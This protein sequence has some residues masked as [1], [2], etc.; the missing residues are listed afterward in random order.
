MIEC[1]N[2]HT[3]YDEPVAFC[4]ACGTRLAT[5]GA[6][7]RAADPLI[8]VVIDD[9]YRL[10]DL[11]GRGGMGAVYRVEHVKMGKVMAMKLLHG[12]LG[13]DQEVARRFR[14]EAEA[15]SRLTHL[16]T[17]SVFDFGSHQGMMYLVM[18]Y[19]EGRDLAEVLRIEGPMPA[20]RV[21]HVLVQVCSALIEA[22]DKGIVHRDIKPENILVS[23]QYDYPDFV[24]V[25]D[26]GLAKLRDVRDATKITKEGNLVGTPY[27]M[28]PEHIRGEG[29]DARSDV[30]SLGAVMYKLLTGETPFS[31]DTPM[32]VLTKHLTEKIDPPSR[33]FPQR[34]IPPEA[35]RIV[36]RAMAKTP[37]DRY[38][39]AEEM[40]QELAELAVRLDP[41]SQHR[42]L[43]GG[44]GIP[45]TSGAAEKGETADDAT[46]ATQ[47]PAPSV[48]TEAEAPQRST[49]PSTVTVGAREVTLGTREDVIHFEKRL[50]RKRVVTTVSLSLLAAAAI[51]AC[52]YWAL[53]VHGADDSLANAETEPND[54]PATA[55]PLAAGVRLAGT[56]SKSAGQQDVDWY[57]L[58]SPD[59]AGGAWGLQ[60]DV[61]GVPGLDIGL[62][63]V[64]PSQEDPLARVDRN[65]QGGGESI[66]PLRIEIPEV[67]L[68]LQEMRRPGVP[69]SSFAQA[70]YTVSYQAY[71]PEFF[72]I[73]PNDT[74]SQASP[75]RVGEI[76]NGV[77][78][79][80]DDIDWYCLPASARASS[81][82]VTPIPEMQI[83]LGFLLGPWNEERVVEEQGTGRG[84][85]AAIPEGPGPVCFVLRAIR[86]VQ[87]MDRPAE[88]TLMA[89]YQITVK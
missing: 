59:P 41:E 43:S 18:E 8:G 47:F 21:A 27:Y 53:F 13:Q 17:V 83:Q 68:M 25:L 54:S 2:C 66:P 72:E 74:R 30:Y 78:E 33:R 45:N 12:E 77:I 1:P 39:S 46:P 81:V 44:D 58:N 50:R 49:R 23:Q 26:F 28:A 82:T 5:D 64:D 14:L 31:A 76:K 6:P 73:E 16:N 85:T 22:H 71:A 69:P 62:Q 51:A 20:A 52:V 34:A 24:K 38:A 55:D 7:A 3:T 42:R 36:L 32:G 35:D 79:V 40:R 67:Y 80:F 89:P 88:S 75:I 10:L 57:R 86:S 87:V 9:R 4:G 63:L 19:I 65:G 70:A 84:L 56:I 60:V 37:D 15:V 48:A 11:I 29:V 61:S